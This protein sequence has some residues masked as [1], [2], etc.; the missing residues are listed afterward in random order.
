MEPK[1]IELDASS[2]RMVAIHDRNHP[3]YPRAEVHYLARTKDGKPVLYLGALG[4]DNTNRLV[5]IEEQYADRRRQ[6]FYKGF[7]LQSDVNTLMANL[8][9]SDD[10]HSDL[11][12]VPSQEAVDKS[13][14]GIWFWYAGI[15]EI[16]F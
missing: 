5:G 15:E 12:S 11:T 14:E 3:R 6:E 10:G 7:A 9:H 8:I 4:E 2:V 13:R 1:E 16:K